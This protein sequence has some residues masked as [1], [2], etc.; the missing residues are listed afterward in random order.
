MSN[1]CGNTMAYRRK[2]FQTVDLNLWRNSHGNCTAFWESNW[3]PPQLTT[4]KVT[5]RRNGS[6]K[7]W[8]NTF[9]SLSTKDK[10]TGTDCFPLQNS[11]TTTTSIPPPVKFRF[12]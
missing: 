8:N 6:T 12:S 4:L 5:D 3:R 1:M 2:S 11:N 10:M 9:E 7:N